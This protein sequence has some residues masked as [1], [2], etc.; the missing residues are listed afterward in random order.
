VG[1]NGESTRLAGQI[2]WLVGHFA[3]SSE[4]KGLG[5]LWLSAIQRVSL[6]HGFRPGNLN[7]AIRFPESPFVRYES[8]GLKVEIGAVSD[9]P[10]AEVI[11]NLLG[12]WQRT[13]GS[14]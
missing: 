14:K 11:N 9:P 1:A 4:S 8:A 13:R 7:V 10:K 2:D 5:C 3:T 12:M 6:D